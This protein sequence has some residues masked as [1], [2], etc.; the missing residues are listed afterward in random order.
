M[1]TERRYWATPIDQPVSLV[2]GWLSDNHYIRTR[3]I[4]A[5]CR[6]REECPPD[7]PAVVLW[8][9]WFD[10]QEP[11]SNNNNDRK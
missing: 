8:S 11:P 9:L 6:I 3:D 10:G 4:C 5:I 2:A 7:N 1:V